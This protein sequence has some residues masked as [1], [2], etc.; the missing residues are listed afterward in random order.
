MTTEHTDAIGIVAGK[1]ASIGGGAS[2]FLF[3]LTAN[4]AA[5]LAGCLVGCAGLLV[6][7]YFS[8]RRDRR[9]QLEHEIRMLRMRQ[10]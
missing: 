6:Q 1:V 2:A 5:A 4:E 8:R 10:P 3:G 7:V 9:E